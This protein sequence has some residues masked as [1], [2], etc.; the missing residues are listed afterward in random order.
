MKADEMR[1]PESQ[2][3]HH[4]VHPLVDLNPDLT[5]TT[6]HFDCLNFLSA[7]MIARVQ[8]GSARPPGWG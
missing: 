6:Q 4:P 3:K 1:Q 2:G 5:I 7:S 8:H